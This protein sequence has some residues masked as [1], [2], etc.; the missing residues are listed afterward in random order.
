[1]SRRSTTFRTLTASALL[2]VALAACGEAGSSGTESAGGSTS[3]AS[4]A[5]CEPVAGKELVV[6]EDDEHL[7]TVDN[8]IPAA[9]AAAVADQPAVLDRKSTRLNSSHWE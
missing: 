5:A 2:V 9:N 7:Q 3:T 8:I 1:M 6:L 4:G